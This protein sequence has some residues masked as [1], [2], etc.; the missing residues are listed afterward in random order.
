L[1]VRD[2]DAAAALQE[3]RSGCRIDGVRQAELG[4]R[5]AF[6]IGLRP[7]VI[8][9]CEFLELEPRAV[10]GEVEPH[11]RTQFKPRLTADLAPVHLAV[12]PR[13]ADDVRAGRIDLEAGRQRLDRL[14]EDFT[15]IDGEIPDHATEAVAQIEPAGAELT[16]RP[17]PRHTGL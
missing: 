11:R 5:E 13:N 17:V 8:D 12:D 15:A 14:L 6:E 1:T 2:I 16:R 10:E 9:A 3:R 4:R 7:E